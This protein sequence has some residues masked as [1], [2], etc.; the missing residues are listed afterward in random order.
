MEYW[1]IDKDPH[2]PPMVIVIRF[3][4]T[5]GSIQYNPYQ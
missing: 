1:L 3:N 2:N 4:D 5:K